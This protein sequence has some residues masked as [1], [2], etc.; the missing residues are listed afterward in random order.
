MTL[1]EQK[2]QKYA[3]LKQ[4]KKEIEE[5]L[6]ELKPE[7]E[8]QMKDNDGRPVE[9]DHGKFTL[10]KNTVGYEWPD[11]IKSKEAQVAKQKEQA[12]ANGTAEPK[13]VEYVQ[14]RPADSE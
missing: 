2:F 9:S 5:R 14:F 11:S 7:I 8:E 6:D 3:E 12:K 13:E 1:D 10:V 4:Q